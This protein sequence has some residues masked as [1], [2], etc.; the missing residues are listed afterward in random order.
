MKPDIPPPPLPPPSHP[1][2]VRERNTTP[3]SVTLSSLSA[4]RG[5]KAKKRAMTSSVPSSSSFLTSWPLGGSQIKHPVVKWACCPLRK[6]TLLFIYNTANN[7]QLIIISS[8]NT[9]KIILLQTGRTSRSEFFSCSLLSQTSEDIWESSVYFFH[10]IWDKCFKHWVWQGSSYMMHK[11]TAGGLAKKKKKEKRTGSKW[12]HFSII[13]P[14]QRWLQQKFPWV[15]ELKIG[16]SC[17][18][19]AIERR[20]RRDQS[21]SPATLRNMSLCLLIRFRDNKWKL[22]LSGPFAFTNGSA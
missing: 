19:R 13:S 21:I 3:S 1:S 22:G 15:L 6:P 14:A 5:L 4:C 9:Y 12:T 16:H 18:T 10:Q 7:I 20:R 17:N 11:L 2:Q 8:K